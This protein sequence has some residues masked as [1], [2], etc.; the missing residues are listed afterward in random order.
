MFGGKFSGSLQPS[1]FSAL[2]KAKTIILKNDEYDVFGDGSV[3]IKS[4]PG[5]TQGHQ[6]LYV[7][8][9]KTGGGGLSGG[10]YHR[11][12]ERGLGP[13]PTFEGK[14]EPAPARRRADRDLPTKK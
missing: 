12:P 10:L 7:K 8:L 5:H 11:P 13:G 3:I 6:V 9:A 14:P 4:A 2:Q 1:T